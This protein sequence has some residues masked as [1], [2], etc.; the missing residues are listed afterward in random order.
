MIETPLFGRFM[1]ENKRLVFSAPMPYH[2]LVRGSIG[3]G[4]GMVFVGLVEGP[5]QIEAGPPPQWWIIIGA[6]VLLAGIAAA[7]SLASISFDLQE[8]HYRR[9]QGPGLFNTLR[10]GST[11]ELD[12]LVLISEPNSRIPGGGV[13]YHLVLHWKGESQPI[14]VLQQDTRML[15]PGQP[16]NIGAHQLLSAGLRYA[17]A[18]GIPFFDNSHIAARCPVPIWR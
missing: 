1:G 2:Y 6:M 15:P 5:T 12:A 16:L 14:M 13:T 3:A 11:N 17:Q 8:R 4:A 7:F 10:V 9:R 18:I